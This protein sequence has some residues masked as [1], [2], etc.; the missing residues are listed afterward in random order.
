MSTT[1]DP[2][3]IIADPPALDIGTFLHDLAFLHECKCETQGH[4]PNIC[5]NAV[6]HR[7]RCCAYTL[8]VCDNGAAFIREQ[9]E[10]ITRCADCMNPVTE[11]W[12][13][14]KI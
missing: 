8:N 12:S 14:T 6:T 1:L 7:A 13:L 10:R 9:M 3:P 4:L 11:C 2:R 5:T